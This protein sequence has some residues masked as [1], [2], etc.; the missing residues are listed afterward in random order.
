M[1]IQYAI[2]R[3]PSDHTIYLNEGTYEESFIIDKNLDLIGLG[4]VT[5]TA[6]IELKEINH[7]KGVI[8][9]NHVD[10][11]LIKDLIITNDYQKDNDYDFLSGLLILNSNAIIEAVHVENIRL[12]ETNINRETGYGIYINND[13][14]VYKTITIRNSV[15]SN[16]QKTGIY[17]N[18]KNHCSI[19]NVK[20]KGMGDTNQIIQQGIVFSEEVMGLI[21]HVMISYN[22]HTNVSWYN[23]GRYSYGIVGFSSHVKLSNMT[24]YHNNKTILMSE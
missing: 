19:Y 16:Y 22:Y 23:E 8:I 14:F 9:L 12:N 6:P 18:G 10:S 13:S 17:I 2:D 20:I 11:V 5:I 24:F 4:Q 1:S 3:A 15:I 21:S 7:L